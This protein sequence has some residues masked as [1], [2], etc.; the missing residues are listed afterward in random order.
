MSVILKRGK[1][2]KGDVIELIKEKENDGFIISER[3]KGGGVGEGIF[4][5]GV[6]SAECRKDRLHLRGKGEGKLAFYPLTSLRGDVL[7]PLLSRCEK[8]ERRG[9]C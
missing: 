5:I 2:E 3:K 6:R 7:P 4:L 9:C 8:G 1:G